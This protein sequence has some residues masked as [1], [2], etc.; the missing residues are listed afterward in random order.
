MLFGQKNNN[1]EMTED[2]S[3]PEAK[4]P[5]SIANPVLQDS[6][7]QP[8]QNEPNEAPPI[9]QTPLTQMEVNI[10]EINN[11]LLHLQH[12]IYKLAERIKNF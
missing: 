4:E 1:E 12:V 2:T 11:S 5:D 9:L 10:G 7:Y 3:Q 6:A 8:E